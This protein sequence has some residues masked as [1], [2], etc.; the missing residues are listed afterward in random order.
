MGGGSMM[1]T[2]EGALASF[3]TVNKAPIKHL[4]VYFSPKQAG[5]GTPSPENVREI[6]GWSGLT[7]WYTNKNLFPLTD[8]SYRESGITVSRTA[9]KISITG[10]SNGNYYRTVTGSWTADGSSVVL[11]NVP[12][13]TNGATWYVWNGTGNVISGTNINGIPFRPASGLK[14]NLALAIDYANVIMNVEFTPIICKTSDLSTIPVDWSSTIGTVYGGYVDLITG[15]L[16]ETFVVEEPNEMPF[17]IEPGYACQ[18]LH[19]KCN[20]GGIQNY[21]NGM[22]SHWKIT[23]YDHSNFVY[24]NQNGAL[25][26]GKQFFDS[27]GIDYTSESIMAYIA[28]QKQNGTP[29][30]IGAPLITPI[31][32]QLTPTQFS[33][34]IGRNNIWSNADRVEVEYDL[35]ESNDELY[36]RRN[37]LLRSAP[38]IET[39]SGNMAHFETDITAPIK[40]AIVRFSPVQ[41]G[42]G[43]PSLTNVRAINGW[44]GITTFYSG[45][46]LQYAELEQGGINGNTSQETVSTGRLRTKGYIYLKPGYQ[47]AISF[48][49]NNSNLQIIHMFIYDVNSDQVVNYISVG[50]SSPFV[51]QIGSSFDYPIY[52]FRFTLIDTTGNDITPDMVSSIVIERQDATSYEPYNGASISTNWQ[53]A[54]GTIYG[55]YV[56]LVTGEL[57]KT[58]DEFIIGGGNNLAIAGDNY[59]GEQGTN[60]FA[61]I[62]SNCDI[63]NYT[64][65]TSSNLFCNRFEIAN[66]GI[67]TTPDNNIGKAVLNART[68]F[69]MVFDNSLVGINS[70]DTKADRI[71]KI[72]AYLTDNKVQVCFTM[73]TTAR[74]TLSP[75]TLHSLRETNNIWSNANGP[76]EIKYWTH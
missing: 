28:E 12:V 1:I 24:L 55:G 71:S 19:S 30:Q 38:H 18:W 57:V 72:S 31:T 43:D 67:W 29:L 32:H 47:Y 13:L 64:E 46:N 5:E 60:V 11:Y 69:H 14:I 73:K 21:N 2:K 15:E 41:T 27:V 4:K 17:T 37:I 68:Q 61:Y 25:V 6:S 76:V 34:L 42:S 3:Y 53:T 35:A 45:K 33:T 51:F 8:Y 40:S 39:A 9:G 7:T 20:T 49:S 10:T 16:V 50:K 22:S 62:N 44:S 36:R 75:T 26:I 65:I 56:D 54:A 74:Y 66:Y 63:A 70:T 52:K 59:C 58:Y 48:T 23:Q